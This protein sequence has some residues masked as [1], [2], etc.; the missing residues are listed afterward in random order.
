MN[1]ILVHC[2]LGLRASKWPC[3]WP[4]TAETPDP[5]RVM[6]DEVAVG[7]AFCPGICFSPIPVVA[8][9]KLCVC[10]RS[11]ILMGLWVRIP[12]RARMFVS[13]ECCASVKE[14]HG[15]TANRSATGGKK[16]KSF[17]FRCYS[18]TPN[19]V[20]LILWEADADE[21][22]KATIFR[23]WVYI[24]PHFSFPISMLTAVKITEAKVTRLQRVRTLP[25]PSDFS[26]RKKSSARLHSEGK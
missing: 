16:K 4:V 2:L 15:P 23:N 11:L 12:P 3:P 8:W 24:N 13:C 19:F 20:I 22:F 21:T 5:T 18:T 14:V 25:K 1:R 7:Q 26:G 10:D 9:S 6:V 17:L